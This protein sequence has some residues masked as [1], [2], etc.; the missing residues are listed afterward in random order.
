[1]ADASALLLADYLD[2]LRDFLV[3]AG[4][5]SYADASLT[6]AIRQAIG[7]L[8][9]VYGSGVTI[10]DLDLAQ[11]TTVRLADEDLVI[12]GAA[13]YAARMR[14]VDRADS[15]NLGQNMPSTLLD[16][17]KNTLYWFDQ[18]L[19][20][21]KQRILQEST[22]SPASEWTWDESEQNW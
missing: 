17:S 6:E 2:R 16:W 22:S 12:R 7:D 10:E 11:T 4:E 5:V 18:T 1:M 19:R 21:V 9:R 3:D 15:A 8:G 14:A 20:Q 13:G